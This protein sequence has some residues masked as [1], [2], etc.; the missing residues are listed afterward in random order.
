M[1]KR[2]FLI[3]SCLLVSWTVAR[4][5]QQAVND[6]STGGITVA[7][8]GNPDAILL[9]SRQ[10]VPEPGFDESVMAI[11]DD[12]AVRR[13]HAI[14]QFQG[15]PEESA[16]QALAADG[17]SVLHYIPTNALEV[18]VP[19]DFSIEN[20]PSIR[21]LGL[22]NA[23]DKIS[24]TVARLMKE[25]PDERIAVV[26]EF[27]S[28]VAPAEITSILGELAATAIDNPGL[29]D[30][31]AVT[32]LSATD[33]EKIVAKDAVAW[34]I[35]ASEAL[36]TGRQVYFCPGPMTKYGH[37]A[38]YVIVHQG[39]DGPGQGSASLTYYFVNGTPDIAGDI[40]QIEIAEGITE[41]A[42]HVQLY[43]TETSSPGLNASFDCLFATYSHG[44]GSPFDG[45]GGVLAHAFF[46]AN[47]N[48]EPI[49]GDIH[50]DDSEFWRVGYGVDMYSIALHECGHSLGLG[51]SADPN[52]VMYWAYYS[53]YDGLAQDDINGIR[54]IY[55][56]LDFTPPSPDPMTFE[57]RPSA[58][59]SISITMT[60]TLASDDT[61]PIQYQF[62]FYSG[63]PGGT[64]S[65]WGS[66]TYIDNGLTPNTE[67]RYRCRA[68][69][70]GQPRNE[71]AYSSIANAYTLADI[72]G[73]PE[74]TNVTSTT[75][76]LNVHPGPNPSN[77]A[78][79]VTCATSDPEWDHR[80]VNA[81]GNPSNSEVWQTDSQWG[82]TTV[83]GLTPQTEYSFRAKAR[84]DDDIE[85][86]YGRSSSETTLF[87][88]SIPTITEWGM[89]IMALL[90]M[91]TGT[92]AVIRRRG[93]ILK[94]AF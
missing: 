4:G 65:G 42:D 20:H 32:M 78:F 88:P 44:D 36:K 56:T 59:N 74:L 68:R 16:L 39:W 21:W 72:P 47:P 49:A 38:N 19:R 29:P 46:P 35:P 83:Q 85:T 52:A 90:L 33:V 58:A 23:S 63:G 43:F 25:H 84:N 40:E 12:Q 73:A 51:H 30:F 76:D 50:F 41:W 75:I 1:I 9:R 67:Y 91:A 81:S 8:A 34:I 6:P 13:Y 54:A 14:I 18:S 2:L 80:F 10:F 66:R 48:P 27:F 26:I 71:T 57:S 61:P 7:I 77:T 87:E 69:D 28:D 89:I 22:L 82:T 3:L 11:R 86:D 45:P 64:D 55:A 17:V 60:A 31:M 94:R 5:D 37:V 53:P 70:N 15:E 62:D 92:I 79:A 93:K 24:D